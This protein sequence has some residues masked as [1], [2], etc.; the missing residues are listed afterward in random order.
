M[1]AGAAP[2]SADAMYG[3]SLGLGRARRGGALEATG[4]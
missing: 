3:A 2:A 4:G 1:S